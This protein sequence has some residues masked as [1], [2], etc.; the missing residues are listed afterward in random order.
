MRDRQ[1]SVFIGLFVLTLSLLLIPIYNP[2]SALPPVRGTGEGPGPRPIP[3]PRGPIPT[4]PRPNIIISDTLVHYHEFG[5]NDLLQLGK[6]VMLTSGFVVG[7]TAAIGAAVATG[8]IPTV[9]AGAGVVAGAQ[10]YYEK[11]K[12]LHGLGARGDDILYPGKHMQGTDG[13]PCTISAIYINL[14][15]HYYNVINTGKVTQSNGP[16]PFTTFGAS[17]VK[18]HEGTSDPSVEVHWFYD[19]G[20][21]TRYNV[22]YYVD[23]PGCAI[24]G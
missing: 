22:A 12:Q 16:I 24:T 10:G 8:F 6:A 3:I 19:V 1:K 18:S 21:A 17:L 2:V 9:V 5:P 11:M 15:D 13:R 4:P 20:S 23:R 14:L 7:S